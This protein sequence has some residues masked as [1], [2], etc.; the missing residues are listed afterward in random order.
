MIRKAFNP[1]LITIILF[2]FLDVSPATAALPPTGPGPYRYLS[3]KWGTFLNYGLS[4]GPR[5]M[6]MANVGICFPFDNTSFCMNPANL[7]DRTPLRNTS[8]L[9][10]TYAPIYPTLGLIHQY[11]SHVSFS[12]LPALQRYIGGFIVDFGLLNLGVYELFDDFGRELFRSW[13]YF[14]S[15]SIGW[16]HD[17]SWFDMPDH[18]IGIT[19]SA[20]S[21][22][23]SDILELF[24][25]NKYT[26][27]LSFGYRGLFFKNFYCGV[28]VRNIGPGIK[29]IRFKIAEYGNT[30]TTVCGK[31]VEPDDQYSLTPLSTAAGLGYQSTLLPNTCNA[32]FLRIEGDIAKEFNAGYYDNL[33][34]IIVRLGQEE[35][36]MGT[37][38]TRAGIE[39]DRVAHAKQ[40]H[41]GCGLQV[42]NHFSLNF[43]HVFSN[44]FQTYRNG[45]WALSFQA[46][47]LLTWK[48]TDLEWWKTKPGCH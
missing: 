13:E 25:K 2:P 22:A 7:G 35:T 48:R 6:G 34:N 24:G 8:A 47:N 37:L 39:Y 4:L 15:V 32:I 3:Q 29:G 42:V 44:S 9:S 1:V 10:Y 31:T 46:Y 33:S 41:V 12:F 40:F 36:F 28:T 45:Q 26:P 38:Q 43:A 30:T 18:F 27:L 11:Q 19:A 20:V 5:Q 17:L 21:C 14:P 23:G 16:G